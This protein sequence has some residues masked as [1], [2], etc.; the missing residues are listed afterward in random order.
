M[1]GSMG[2]GRWRKAA[3]S[4]GSAPRFRHLPRAAERRDGGGGVRKVN[5]GAAAGGR[6]RVGSAGST[7]T[8]MESPGF[9]R[10]CWARVS[11]PDSPFWVRPSGRTTSYCRCHVVDR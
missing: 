9:Q 8:P 11:G 7:K 10:S 6:C 4:G 5:L 3:K 1:A 2:G